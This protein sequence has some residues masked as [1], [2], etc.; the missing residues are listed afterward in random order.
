LLQLGVVM[1]GVNPGKNRMLFDWP[2]DFREPLASAIPKHP[3]NNSYE[4][5]LLRT[6]WPSSR[7]SATSLP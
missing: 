3:V 6:V 5:P 2:E 7:G 4:Q 1:Y